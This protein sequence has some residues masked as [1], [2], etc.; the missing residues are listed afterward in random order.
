MFVRGEEQLELQRRT[1]P[2]GVHLLVVVNGQ[3][4]RVYSFPDLPALTTFQ[5]D[6]E[7]VLVWTG[8]S[9]AEFWPE[10]R[11]GRDRRRWPRLEERRRW[12]TDGAGAPAVPETQKR[13]RNERR[14]S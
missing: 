8:W 3:T 1:T 2:D 5:A 13:R 6:M 10:R 11:T 12:W 14:R 4:P 9:L 7:H